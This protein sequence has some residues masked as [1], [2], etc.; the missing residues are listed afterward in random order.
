MKIGHDAAKK[1][2]IVCF[3]FQR[4]KFFL[5]SGHLNTFN[6]ELPDLFWELTRS[7]GGFNDP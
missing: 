6:H 2:G 4:D 3:N 7:H 1:G 5:N